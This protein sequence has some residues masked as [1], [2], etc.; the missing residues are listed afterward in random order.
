VA[1]TKSVTIPGRLAA[2]MGAAAVATERHGMTMTG[3][4][5]RTLEGTA[6][7]ADRPVGVGR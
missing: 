5:L 3:L 4:G 6:M 1:A 2:T 7:G